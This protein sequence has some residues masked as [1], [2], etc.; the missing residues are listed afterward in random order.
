MKSNSRLLDIISEAFG[1]RA[2]ELAIS[3][4]IDPLEDNDL[5][6]ELFDTLG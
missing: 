6:E 5:L 1:V 2:S 4:D 3:S